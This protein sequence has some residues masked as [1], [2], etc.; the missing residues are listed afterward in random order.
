MRNLVFILLLVVSQFST[1]TGQAWAKPKGQGFY[2]VDLSTIQSNK[3]FNDA[4]KVVDAEKLANN[5]INFY[6]EVG[7]TNRLTIAGMLPFLALSTPNANMSGVGDA[8][9]A[10]RYA[11]TTSGLAV[12]LTAMAGLPIGNNNSTAGLLT[13][14]GEFN[15]M[16]KV[17]A[18]SGSAKWWSQ[19]GLGFNNRIN[20]YSDEIRWDAEFGYKLMN[21]KLLTMFKL[22]SIISMDNGTVA[23][24]SR[25]G[26]YANEVEYVSPA[27]ELLYYIKKGMGLSLRGAGAVTGRNVQA[28]PQISVGF[29][30]DMK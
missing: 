17:N 12:S 6:G 19:V 28:A 22:A 10:L 15:Q 29:F 27:I 14:D 23:L 4:G 18:G 16:V 26:L 2:K 5:S 13:G 20:G 30:L 7:I 11:L 21:D 25:R 8:D 9:V 3:L 1:L 24:A